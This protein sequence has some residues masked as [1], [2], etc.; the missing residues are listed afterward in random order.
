MRDGD[1]TGCAGVVRTMYAAMAGG[2]LPGALATLAPDVRWTEAAGFPYAGTYTGPDEV[3]T[4]VFARLGGD[5]DG[6]AAVPDMIIDRGDQ[7]AAIGW[8]TGTNRRTGR[9]FS[10]RFVHWFTVADGRITA[11]EQVCDTVQV[12]GALG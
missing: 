10:A 3:L 11:F 6:F 1:V 4:G 9:T 12:A 8:Y 7:V 5:W 2:H